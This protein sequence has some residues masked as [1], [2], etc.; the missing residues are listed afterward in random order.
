MSST[1]L[2]IRQSRTLASFG[3]EIDLVAS[4]ICGED[5]LSLSS[6]RTAQDTINGTIETFFNCTAEAAPAPRPAT[7]VATPAPAPN[8]APSP[9]S[10]TP[11][12]L[13]PLNL[14]NKI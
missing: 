1:T 6:T 7:P 10:A 11:L 12:R 4:A 3:E 14:R 8:P 2:G 13:S 5:N 9:E